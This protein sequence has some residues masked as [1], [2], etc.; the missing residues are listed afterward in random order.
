MKEG[1]FMPRKKRK[2]FC[3]VLLV[4]L[5]CAGCEKKVEV[6][7]SDAFSEA[8]KRI[9][10]EQI[11]VN[12]AW[13]E[14]YLND[15]DTFFPALSINSKWGTEMIPG[16]TIEPAGGTLGL[17]FK[18][19]GNQWT[20]GDLYFPGKNKIVE[21][22]TYLEKGNEELTSIYANAEWEFQPLLDDYNLWLDEYYND[23]NSA[24]DDTKSIKLFNVIDKTTGSKFT[25]SLD[26]IYGFLYKDPNHYEFQP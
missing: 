6:S 21:P 19:E 24:I 18:T 22:T 3:I 13:K 17:I 25:V 10:P 5:I 12:F 14:D 26:F 9:S 4:I 11:N 8:T 20:V 1:I 23:G 15:L 16:V 2:L 7:K